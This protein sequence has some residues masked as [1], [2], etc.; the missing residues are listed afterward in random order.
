[1][2]VD[3]EARQFRLL[4]AHCV[5]WSLAVSLAAGF[6]GAYLLSLGFSIPVTVSLYAAMLAVRFAMRAIMLP[7]VRRLG[8]QRA[9]LVG[10]IVSGMQFLPL[11]HADRALGIIAWI[12]VVSAGECIYWPIC[13]AA[14]AVSGGNGRRGRQLAGR[15]MLTSVTSLV[16]PL[17]GGMLLTHLGPA[18]EFGTATVLCLA[19]TA[20]L[21]WMGSIELGHVPTMRQSLRMADRVGLRAFAADGWMCAGTCIAWP[22]ILFSSMGSSYGALGWAGSAASMAGSLAGLGC[23][24]AID[25]GHRTLLSRYVTIALLAGIML[26]AV[27]TWAPWAAFAANAM[28]AAVGGLYCPMLLSVIYDRAK[29]SGSAYQFHLAAE[30]GWD[31]GAILGCLTTAAVAWSGVPP[32]LAIL[33]SAAGLLVIN[34]CIRAGSTMAANRRIVAPLEHE[35]LAQAA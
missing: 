24:V 18:M 32:T 27:S 6:V 19:S 12:L 30:A 29:L 13:H 20:P 14:N 5:L 1:M 17:A 25:R 3:R 31:A 26:R 28:G 7:V 23:G 4:T 9:M 15:Q 34:R 16:A 10:S 8:M 33:P 2:N 11:I 21:F 35:G 22:I